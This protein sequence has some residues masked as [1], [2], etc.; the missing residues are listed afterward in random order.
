MKGSEVKRGKEREKLT[1]K[2][3]SANENYVRI[4]ILIGLNIVDI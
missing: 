2:W 4:K 1:G 3:V